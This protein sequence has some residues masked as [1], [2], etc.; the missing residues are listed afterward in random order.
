[1]TEA[2]MNEVMKV[3]R[4]NE[5]HDFKDVE[6]IVTL[7]GKPFPCVTISGALINKGIAT[8]AVDPFGRV[9]LDSVRA[10]VES[11]T[12]DIHWARNLRT[13]QNEEQISGGKQFAIETATILEALPTAARESFFTA[14]FDYMQSKMRGD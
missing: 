2:T 6:V 4:W 9:E 3:E 12:L 1:M 5:K 8:I 10:A 11:G 13:E 14:F 7:D